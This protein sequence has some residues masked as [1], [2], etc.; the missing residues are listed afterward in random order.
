MNKT[1]KSLVALTA[2]GALA[3]SGMV[4]VSSALAI[5]G[6]DAANIESP[7]TNVTDNKIYNVNATLTINNV[8]QGDAF[9][10]YQLLFLDSE[11]DAGK[12]YL[13][14]DVYRDAIKAGIKAVLGTSYQ[15]TNFDTDAKI[16]SWLTT[17]LTGGTLNDDG[18]VTMDDTTN[19]DKFTAGFMGASPDNPAFTATAAEGA[20]SVEVSNVPVGFYLIEHTSV[21]DDNTG[22]LT[23]YTTSKYM[24]MNISS[25]N[26]GNNVINLKNG[27]VTLDKTITNPNAQDVNGTED[28][29]SYK[30]GDV[31]EYKLVGT[32][33]DNF[34]D[35]S[36][37]NYTFSDTLSEGLTLNED[38]VEVTVDP[39]G[40]GGEKDPIKVYSKGAPEDEGVPEVTFG[41]DPT[42]SVAMGNLV[43]YTNPDVTKASVITVTY[44][45]TVNA[46]AKMG[47][48]GNKNEAKITFSN[49][50]NSDTD[51]E[52]PKDIVTAYSFQ[53]DVNKTDGNEDPLAGA[54]FTLY[55]QGED[56]EWHP[57]YT[58]NEGNDVAKEVRTSQVGD[59]YVAKFPQLSAGIYKL[60]ETTVPAG[61][62]K[63][64]DQFLQVVA[65][66]YVATDTIPADKKVGDIKS[67]TVQLGTVD[68]NGTFTA[69]GDAEN[70]N[71]TDGIVGTTVI[72]VAGSE[73]PST[74][75]M[76]TVLL[77][78][79]GG[80]VV[81]IAAAGLTIALK[82]R[83]S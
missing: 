65:T 8:V 55:R 11:S 56:K 63:A 83:Q 39:D 50:P 21:G 78:T 49:N 62:N 82:R 29:A 80:L 52:T 67:L 37:F 73:L 30:V 40:E 22:D 51:S 13:V 79:V 74:G 14:N 66:Y 69:T 76:G 18:T 35:F 32:L 44:S 59:K 75:G 34:A 54:G 10:G 77:Y 58:D 72:N 57:W 33:P 20:T 28:A 16:I 41:T 48:A 61:Y 25:L 60:E 64:D 6:T 81:L 7:T 5:N 43:N 68:E 36:T 19:I 17:N 31:V 1:W 42:L 12:V 53:L 3:M 24:A 71:I 9:K 23:T 4:G 27:T 70:G 15:D 38:S 46:L 45:A 47:A 2:G 26:G